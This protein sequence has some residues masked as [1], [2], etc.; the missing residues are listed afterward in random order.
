MKTEKKIMIG[1]S[2]MAYC[3]A[4]L[5]LAG[6]TTLETVQNPDGTTTERHIPDPKLTTGLEAAKAANT[7][8]APFNPLAYWIELGLSAV[9]AGSIWVAKRKND[10]AS[11]NALLLK[12]VI[13]AVNQIGDENAKGIIKAHATAEGV[14][15]QLNVAVRK[16]ESGSPL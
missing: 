11:A 5:V 9:T 4:L 3:L 15:R 14:E 7:A 16:V 2:V 1:L 12:T 6:C 10:K 8:S 13:D